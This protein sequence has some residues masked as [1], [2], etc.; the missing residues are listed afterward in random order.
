MGSCR[1]IAAEYQYKEYDRL[2]MPQFISG[3]NDDRVI[4]GTHKDV[5]TLKDIEDAKG[6]CVLL[7]PLLTYR[8]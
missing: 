4:D 1:T 7:W 8:R 6:E 3:L 2:Q 5:A